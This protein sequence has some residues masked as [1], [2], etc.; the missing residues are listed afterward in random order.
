[1]PLPRRMVSA[2]GVRLAVQRVLSERGYTERAQALSA[3]SARHSG[4]AVAADTLERFA[5]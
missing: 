1:V 3:W 4:D 2:R 5:A